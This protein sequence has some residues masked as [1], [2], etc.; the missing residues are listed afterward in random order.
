MLF[1]I[2]LEIEKKLKGARLTF[3]YVA[4]EEANDDDNNEEEKRGRKK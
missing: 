3:K 2:I 1:V 4:D